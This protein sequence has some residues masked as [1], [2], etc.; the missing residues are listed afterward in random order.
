MVTNVFNLVDNSAYFVEQLL[1]RATEEIATEIEL[2]THHIAVIDCSGSMYND[3][4]EIRKQLKNKLPMLVKDDDTVSI[5]WFSG[6]GQFGI[7]LDAV[8]IRSITDFSSVNKAIDQ[9][10]KPVG[11]TG[12]VEPLN[13]VGQLAERLLAKS[14]NHAVSLFFMSDGYDNQ[15][16]REQILEV[17]EV[18]NSKVS[19]TTIVEYGW[20]CNHPLMVEMATAMG[21]QLIFAENFLSYEP[22]F[23]SALTN[24]PLGGKKVEVELTV[25]AL[26]NVV[27]TVTETGVLTFAVKDGLVLVPEGIETLYYLTDNNKYGGKTVVKD[28]PKNYETALY[29]GMSVYSQMMLSDYVWKLL[30]VTGDVRFIN[31]FANCFGKQ[32]YNDFNTVVV[33][34]VFDSSK[35]LVDG[36]DRNLVPAEDAFTVIDLLQI[37]TKDK[38]NRFYPRHPEFRYNR[39]SRKTIEKNTLLTEDEQVEVE[40]LLNNARTIKQVQAAQKRLDE[41]LAS[42]PSSEVKFTPTGEDGYPISDLVTNENRPNISARICVFGNVN[43]PENEYG[44]P[45][46]LNS[47]IYRNYTIIRDGIINVDTLPVSLT[48]KTFKQLS[49]EGVV[50][51]KF[52]PETI[53]LLDLRSL[54]VINRKMVKDVSANNLFMLEYELAKTKAAQKVFKYFRDQ[55]SP[56]E[57]KTFKESYGVEGMNWLKELGITEYNGFNPPRVQDEAQDMYYGKELKVSLKGISSLPKVEDVIKRRQEGKKLTIS[58]K[59]IAN[60]LDEVNDYMN[61]PAFQAVPDE[62]KDEALGRRMYEDSEFYIEQARALMYSIAKIKFSVIV[63]QIWFREFSSLDENSLTLRLDGDEIVCKVEMKEVEIKI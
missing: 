6:R 21:G 35:R 24:R 46:T 15:W 40:N 60:A 34:A 42:K 19:A 3:L 49:K 25:N 12:F 43:I 63:G 36:Q 22:V 30:K 33:E 53:Y 41:L 59:L 14:K 27:Y 48:E 56:K 62:D 55:V 31:M 2:P 61:S 8:K 18:L 4:P 17:C 44:I 54:P 52:D 7:L 58:Q 51:G 45:E 47:R 29:A 9:W 57:S 32:K 11:L 10:L 13:E 39:T 5:I 26:N 28:L 23:E 37:L 20:Y 50:D 1:P 16:K 38:A